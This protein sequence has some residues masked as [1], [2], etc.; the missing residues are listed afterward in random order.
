MFINQYLESQNWQLVLNEQNLSLS[1]QYF[2]NIFYNC[3]S[4]YVPKKESSTGRNKSM[5]FLRGLI[6]LKD[7]IIRVM[8]HIFSNIVVGI[9]NTY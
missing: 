5:W 3:F 9:F 6:H 7:T 8:K 2:L 4:L 1:Y